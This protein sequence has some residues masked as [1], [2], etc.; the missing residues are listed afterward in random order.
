MPRAEIV[1]GFSNDKENFKSKTDRFEEQLNIDNI[2][3]TNFW[4]ADAYHFQ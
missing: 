1:H 4:F 3:V 2:T